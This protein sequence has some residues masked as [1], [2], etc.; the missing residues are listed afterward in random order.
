MKDGLPA[1]GWGENALFCVLRRWIL[2]FGIFLVQAP[3]RVQTA[4]SW[5]SF[6]I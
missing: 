3:F 1:L 6:V 2:G 5:A 4:A